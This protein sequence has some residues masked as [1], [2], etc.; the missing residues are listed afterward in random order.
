MPR[1]F[2][3]AINVN[4]GVGAVLMCSCC[5]PFRRTSRRSDARMGVTADLPDN[6][7]V[8][9]VE[10]VETTRRGGIVA[11]RPLADK[12]APDDWG[13]CFDNLPPLFRLIIRRGVT[14]R[15][16]PENGGQDQHKPRIRLWQE[17]AW[18]HGRRPIPAGTSFRRHPVQTPAMQPLAAQ[19]LGVPV[20]FAPLVP[21]DHPDQIVAVKLSRNRCSLD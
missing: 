13:Q 21:A 7:Y 8:E 1:L 9:R 2:V 12:L 5:G 14:S 4:Q 20:S 10:R 11:E 17:R 15:P 6:V 16:C 19:Q 18:L 3:H